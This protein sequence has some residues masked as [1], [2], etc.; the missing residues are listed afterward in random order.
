MRKEVKIAD[1]TYEV[2]YRDPIKCIEALFSDPE[3]ADALLLKPERHFTDQ[4]KKNRYYHEMNTGI[5]WWKTQVRCA[6]HGLV[7]LLE[8]NDHNPRLNLRSKIAVPL[9]FLS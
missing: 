3:F 5:W 2:Y 6:I 4:T 1:E 8:S 9:L 7:L